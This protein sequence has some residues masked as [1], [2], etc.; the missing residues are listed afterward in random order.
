MKD[1]DFIKKECIMIKV[2]RQVTHDED[3]SPLNENIGSSQI[4]RKK[5]L[6]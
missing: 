3:A 1:G 4:I 6:I 2:K 5:K